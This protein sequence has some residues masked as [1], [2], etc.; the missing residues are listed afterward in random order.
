[1]E[2]TRHLTFADIVAIN[3]AAIQD[4]GG[5]WNGPQNLLNSGPLS[6][7]LEAV[8]SFSFGVDRYPTIIDKAAAIGYH[9][10]TRHIFHD[11]NKR[12]GIQSCVIFLELNG[13]EMQLDPEDEVEQMALAVASGNNAVT[14]Q[15]FAAWVNR[16]TRP[17]PKAPYE[18]STED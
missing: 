13:L 10:I 6:Y 11:G 5:N 1:M 7:I 12:T 17:F 4:S 9:I 16:R 3:K 8:R 18:V 2:E 14:E 15:E